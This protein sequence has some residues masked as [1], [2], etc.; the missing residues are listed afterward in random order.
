[1]QGWLQAQNRRRTVADDEGNWMI[2]DLLRRRL[3]SL[4][5]RLHHTV[6]EL[7]VVAVGNEVEVL[8]VL[9]L[10]KKP[11]GPLKVGVLLGQLFLELALDLLQLG[12]LLGKL[13][14]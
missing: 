11:H 6:A 5:R 4:G 7:Q 8:V 2:V 3:A 10:L 14:V 1:M 9:F 12:V 13:G